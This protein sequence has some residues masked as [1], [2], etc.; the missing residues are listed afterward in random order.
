MLDRRIFADDGRGLNEFLVDNIPVIITFWL[1]LQ[2]R[3]NTTQTSKEYPYVLAHRQSLILNNPT[4]VLYG[5]PC[6]NPSNLFLPRLSLIDP[7]GVLATSEDLHLISLKLRDIY[8][9]QHNSEVILRLIRFKAI[10]QTEGTLTINL[11]YEFG[12]NPINTNEKTLTLLYDKTPCKV[13]C[14]IDMEPMDIKTFVIDRLEDTGNNFQWIGYLRL[15]TFGFLAHVSLSVF[16]HAY[17]LLLCAFVL[18]LKLQRT[19][20]CGLLVMVGLYVV[21]LTWWIVK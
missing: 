16:A 18:H 21:M 20:T 19:S 5:S 17:F 4:H 10:D 2:P 15:P 6:N 3:I 1:T 14:Q 11:N 7:E 9:E 8:W 13:P 12:L